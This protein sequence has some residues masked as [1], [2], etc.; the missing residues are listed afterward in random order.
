[1]STRSWVQVRNK[2]D[3]ID[4]IWSRSICTII[5]I[6][7]S[8]ICEKVKRAQ[9]PSYSPADWSA[10][11]QSP[12]VR[13]PKILAVS[14]LPLFLSLW[15]SLREYLFGDVTLTRTVPIWGVLPRNNH[16]PSLLQPSAGHSVDCQRPSPVIE[17]GTHESVKLSG[18]FPQQQRS[19]AYWQSWGPAGATQSWPGEGGRGGHSG[20]IDK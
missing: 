11:S 3:V 1:M 17:S 14:F 9:V 13:L 4:V 20:W 10:F 19:V 7:Y 16:S 8:G 5:E 18:Q 6:E 2:R 12:F 15:V